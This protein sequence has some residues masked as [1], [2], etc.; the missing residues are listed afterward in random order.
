MPGGCGIVA[1]T[2]PE[3]DALESAFDG[4]LTERWERELRGREA[5]AGMLCLY[6]VSTG[7]YNIFP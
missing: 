7:G 5:S 6:L 4:T 2:I 3:F 1:V